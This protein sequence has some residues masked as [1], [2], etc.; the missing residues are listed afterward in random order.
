VSD[1]LTGFRS[2]RGSQ[3]GDLARLA[4]CQR[5]GYAFGGGFAWGTPMTPDVRR[6]AS[7]G[8]KSRLGE[9]FQGPARSHREVIAGGEDREQTRFAHDP[10][11]G[12]TLCPTKSPHGTVHLGPDRPRLLYRRDTPTI[13]ESKNPEWIPIRQEKSG[14]K[15]MILCIL[16]PWYMMDRCAT[17]MIGRGYSPGVRTSTIH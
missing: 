17:R 5:P 10:R 15:M 14:I 6:A 9:R 7:F 8:K 1:L 2:A 12:L 4:G 3:W 16:K 11:G 13:R